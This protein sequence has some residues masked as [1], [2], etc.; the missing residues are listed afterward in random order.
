MDKLAVVACQLSFVVRLVVI[1]REQK[2]QDG[3]GIDLGGSCGGWQEVKEERFVD[4][5]SISDMLL[6]VVSLA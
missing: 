2:S 5:L 3:D 4:G 1:E 6:T